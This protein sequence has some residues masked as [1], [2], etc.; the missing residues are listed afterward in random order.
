MP[1]NP[2]H[3]YIAAEKEYL[4]AQTLDEKIKCLE[5][6][7]R[8]SPKHKSS[9]NLLAGLRLRLKKFLEK[10][11]KNKKVGK[12]SLRGI[13]KEHFQCVLVGL[14]SSGKSSLLAKLTNAKPKI[15]S[16]P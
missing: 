11:E 1:V 16:H 15:S 8:T 14:P 12:T 6:M 13:R 4:N 3:E 10:K 5:L 2:G 9:E 7:I